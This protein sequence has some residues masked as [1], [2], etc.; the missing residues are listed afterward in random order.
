MA[1]LSQELT[2]DQ[3]PTDEESQEPDTEAP[4]ADGEE[5]ST[6][7]DSGSFDALKARDKIR[8]INSENRNLRKRAADAE[9]KAK[10]SEDSTQRVSQLEAENLRLRIGM[11]HGLPEQLISRLRGNTEEDVLQDAEALLEIF[12]SKAPP[13]RQ[14]R[15]KLRGGGDPTTDET[16]MS[17]LD[18]F[19]ADVFRR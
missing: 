14:P 7:D 17:D 15:E 5:D 19:A 11:K 9:A 3:E 1:E 8:K 4:E 6:D 12:E 2:D 13:S 16:D 18:K 10:N